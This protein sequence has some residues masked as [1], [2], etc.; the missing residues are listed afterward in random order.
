MNDTVEIVLSLCQAKTS[1]RRGTQA[2]GT[3]GESSEKWE[4][5]GI[6]L[7]NGIRGNI[8]PGPG[9][10][11]LTYRSDRSAGISSPAALKRIEVPPKNIH[12]R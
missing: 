1:V 3:R 6:P 4:I 12:Q 10:R 8:S 11:V 5:K 7:L 9:H 2:A